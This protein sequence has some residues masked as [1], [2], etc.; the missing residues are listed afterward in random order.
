MIFRLHP[1]MGGLMLA[2]AFYAAEAIGW[3]VSR[4]HRR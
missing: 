4:S 3:V 1:A 2:A